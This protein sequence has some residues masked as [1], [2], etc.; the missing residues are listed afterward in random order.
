MDKD[1]IPKMSLLS[2]EKSVSSGKHNRSPS[3]PIRRSISTD[4]GSVTKSKIKTDNVENQPIL[5]HLI[6]ARVP[7]NKSLVTMT[8][9]TE[10]NSNVYLHSQEAVKH[11]SN[12]SEPVY[13]LQKVSLRK[14]HQ[15][16]EEEQFKQPFAVV[17]QTGV[18]KSKADNNKVKARHLQQSP[19][20]IRKTDEIVEPPRKRDYSEPEND[21]S[22]MESTINSASN[23]RKKRHDISRNSQNLE[24]RYG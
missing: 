4:R 2:E 8:Q 17:K 3:P 18:R 5:K 14:V 23:V 15:E 12:I 6:P 7:V 10:H 21:F 20:R 16:H 22:F 1:S 9:S 19:F 24:S 11:G 13:N